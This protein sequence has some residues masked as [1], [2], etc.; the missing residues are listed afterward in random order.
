MLLDVLSW[1]FVVV[2]FVSL[3]AW[4]DRLRKLWFPSLTFTQELLIWLLLV[5][6][7][8]IATSHRGA[9]DRFRMVG[10]DLPFIALDTSTGRLCAVFDAK[11]LEKFR[12]GADDEF[13][14]AALFPPCGK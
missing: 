9:P 10:Q 8:D 6:L 2:V 4:L 11:Q 1:I 7:V 14:T 5:V 12:K 3:A 13:K